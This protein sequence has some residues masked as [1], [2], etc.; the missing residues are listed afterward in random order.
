[1]GILLVSVP[2][3]IRHLL[4]LSRHLLIIIQRV[5]VDLYCLFRH[6]L[7]PSLLHLCP[8]RVLLSLRSRF[9]PR[10]RPLCKQLQVLLQV[11][12]QHQQILISQQ[13]LRI[14]NFDI[15]FDIFFVLM[16][17]LR[18][19]TNR[20]EKGIVREKFIFTRQR[21]QNYFSTHVRSQPVNLA[22]FKT[23]ET[24]NTFFALLRVREFFLLFCHLFLSVLVSSVATSCDLWV[25]I[26][27]QHLSCSFPSFY[28]ELRERTWKKEKLSNIFL[29]TPLRS[30]WGVCSSR[31]R[32]SLRQFRRFALSRQ[33]L[34]FLLVK[35]HSC[36][37]SN[38]ISFQIDIFT[39]STSS[40]NASTAILQL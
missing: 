28:I 18:F 31:H 24:L 23:Q 7:L 29:A 34:S 13:I 6:L 15:R 4:L 11:L 30:S 36:S 12:F 38:V 27:F 3:R 16:L 20:S 33:K 19:G 17:R 32:L 35:I 39:K 2:L 40:F 26:I 8:L 14:A 21:K 10:L 9:R 1:M 37:T 5:L 22:R 25:C